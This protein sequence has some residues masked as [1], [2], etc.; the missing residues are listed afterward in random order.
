MTSALNFSTYQ[1]E[2]SLGDDLLVAAVFAKTNP[3]KNPW[4]SG[5]TLQGAVPAVG[6]IF[7]LENTIPPAIINFPHDVAVV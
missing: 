4:F 2:I 3:G 6:R 7:S 1:F 5:L